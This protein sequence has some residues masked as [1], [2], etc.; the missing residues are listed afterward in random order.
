MSASDRFHA[1][2]DEGFYSGGWDFTVRSLLGKT[3]R[4]GADPGEVLATISTLD[5]G[6]GDAWFLAWKSLGERLAREAHA[7]RAAGHRVSAS[8]ASLRAA[9]YYAVCVSSIDGFSDPSALLPV[10]R[11]HRDAWDNFVRTTAWFC[12]E[13]DIPYE[14]MSLPGWFFAPDASGAQRPTLVMNNGSDGSISGLWCEGAEAALER[15]YNVLMFDGPGQ[16]SML[17]E[18]GVP[19]RHDWEAVL[20][21][22]L[23]FLV[24]RP[25]VDGDA[26][27]LYGVSQAGYW[28]PRALAFE[29]RFRAAIADGG[30]VDVS[31]AWFRHIPDELLALYRSGDAEA[32]DRA[33]EQGASA[34]PHAEEAAQL[35]AF[36][37][38]PYGTQG[39][40]Q[41]LNEVSSYVITAELAQ[42]ITTPLYI[43]DCDKE[44]F[45]PG[46][47][48]ELAALVPG[49]TLEPFRASEGASYH[50]QPM[51]RALTE[52]RMFN[53]LDRLLAVSA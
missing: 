51:A 47:P 26:L 52:E 39:Y 16:Q 8:T 31:R 20:T 25:E 48:P 32:F 45:Y 2:Y 28:V 17:F 40:W 19:F 46:Q 49:S 53:W 30:V 14:N 33:I 1:V 27:A 4:R 6:D 10:F 29:H 50:C 37:A 7:S 41:T 42:N 44:Q 36:R 21:P 38:R 15:G 23:D 34:D 22:V 18:H 3:H 35:W 5:E 11:E 9:N 13:V 43:T 12:E 24:Q